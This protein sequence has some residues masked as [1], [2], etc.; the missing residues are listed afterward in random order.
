MTG[1]GSI[2]RRLAFWYALLSMALIIV[3]GSVMYWVL[4]E[5][6]R[7]EDDQVLIS[8]LAELRAVLEQHGDDYTYLREE[9]ERETTTSPGTYLRVL[10]GRGDVIAESRVSNTQAIHDTLFSA[11]PWQSNGLG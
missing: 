5:R 9:V 2:A 8:K 4:K 10:D 6:L 11:V 3:F 1:S 7:T